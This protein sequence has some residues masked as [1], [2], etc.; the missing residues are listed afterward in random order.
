MDDK[1]IV[2]LY[3]QRNEDAISETQKKYGSFCFMIARNILSTHEDIEECVNDTW[4]SAWNK[5][6]PIIPKSLKA[7][8]GK[9]VRDISLSRYRANHAK[10]R[11]NGMEI[12]LDELEECIPSDFSVEESIE[13][14]ELSEILNEWLRTLSREE[15]TLFV[16]RY[17]YGDPIKKLAKE[18]GLSENQMSQKMMKLRKMFKTYL[19]QKEVLL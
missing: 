6:P 13:F 7:F 9:I 16:K 15:M 11:Y 19:T 5:I 8:L 14:K 17:Y 4:I 10:K 12:M 18:Q 2:N 1:D 3:L